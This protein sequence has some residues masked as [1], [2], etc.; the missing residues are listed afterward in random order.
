MAKNKRARRPRPAPAATRQGPPP[1][2][3]RLAPA[4]EDAIASLARL[5]QLA[6][7]DRLGQRFALDELVALAESAAAELAM[8][9]QDLLAAIEIDQ[10]NVPLAGSYP[11]GDLWAG[12]QRPRYLAGLARRAGEDPHP[13]TYAE[14]LGD[15][16]LAADLNPA[17][18]QPTADGGRCHGQR[19]RLAGRRRAEA[20]WTHLRA[21]RRAEIRADRDRAVAAHSCRSCD[22]PAGTQCLDTAG[23]PTQ[24]HTARLDELSAAGG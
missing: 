7:S 24:P 14:R 4:I 13:V 20:C 17:C 16:D 21:D 11:T 2:G 18:P 15:A 8:H 23:K 3:D 19:V 12:T 6:Q 1:A 5:A 10:T 9:R 22:A